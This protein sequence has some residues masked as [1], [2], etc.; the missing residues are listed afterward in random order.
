MIEIIVAI[1]VIGNFL[2]QLSW[3]I[4]TLKNHSH[5]H[6]ENNQENLPD[7]DEI[8]TDSITDYTPVPKSKEEV[9]SGERKYNPDKVKGAFDSFFE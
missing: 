9:F 4:W 3:F 7:H 6:I 5:K 1:G 2:L 8:V